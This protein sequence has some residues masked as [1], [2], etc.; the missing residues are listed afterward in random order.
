M[1][2]LNSASNSAS[3]NAEGDRRSHVLTV[4]LTVFGRYGFRKTS[5]DDVARA[6][7]ISRQGLYLYFTTKQ[8]LF[9]EAVRQEMDAAL[10]EVDQQLDEPRIPTVDRL[11]GALD[12]WLGRFVGT[13]VNRDV[14]SLLEANETQLRD[15]TREHV[16]L[17]ESR[18][19]DAIA[20][21]APATDLKRIG[22]TPDQIAATL[23][24][25]GRAAKF[26]VESRSEFLEKIAA[27]VRLVSAG[28]T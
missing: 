24:T 3:K 20:R 11:I 19:T 5:M 9:R 28:W 21:V 7:D 1:T 16:A 18:L 13:Q 14:G 4:A 22:V 23:I 2:S 10:A 27:A 17:F 12:A 15:L 26:E 6:A 25:F 8:E